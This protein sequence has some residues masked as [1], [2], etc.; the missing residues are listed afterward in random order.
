MKVTLK[1]SLALF[2]VLL[3]LFSFS[4]LK[5]HAQEVELT[6]DNEQIQSSV[7]GYIDG[8]RIASTTYTGYT[9]GGWVDCA[10]ALNAG[11]LTCSKTVTVNNSYSGSLQV[12]KSL[13]EASVG[14]DISKE[15]STTAAFDKDVSARTKIQYRSVYK[16][17][18]VKQNLIRTYLITGNTEIRDTKYVYPKKHSGFEFRLQS[19]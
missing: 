18:K 7:G 8:W 1:Y 6:K 10:F 4:T 2:I 15:W 19:Y 16:N 12:A 17:Y 5:G 13:V 9:Y 11:H 3:S 14:F